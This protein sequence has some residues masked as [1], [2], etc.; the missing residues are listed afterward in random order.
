VRPQA[1]LPNQSAA[2]T[3]TP[4][5]P[6]QT[7]QLPRSRAG[8]TASTGNHGRYPEL[9]ASDPARYEDLQGRLSGLLIRLDDRFEDWDKRLLHEF[10]DAGEFGLALEQMADLLAEVE[11]PLTENERHDM[12]TLVQIMEMGDHVP[13]VLAFCPPAE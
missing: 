3:A 5:R 12:L 4:Y 2:A 9:H 1:S 13:R 6:D 10:I 7:A 11:A 8:T